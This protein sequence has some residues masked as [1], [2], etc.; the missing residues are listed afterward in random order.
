VRADARAGPDRW[1]ASQ[2]VWR[3]AAARR[4]VGAMRT[5]TVVVSL[6]FACA[7]GTPRYASAQ[8]S[9]SLQSQTYHTAW[10]LREGAPAD[11][12]ALAQTRDGYLWLG[13]STGLF[14]F[15]G[16]EFERFV[17]KRSEAL[18][19]PSIASLLAL[20]DGSLYIGY[21][22]GGVSVLTSGHLRTFGV[23]DG[24]RGGSV[25]ALV[26]DSNGV[27]L[28][29]SNDG[30]FEQHGAHWMHISSDDGLPAGSIRYAMV[31][32]VG[33][34][35]VAIL[36]VGIFSRERHAA[37]FVRRA[38]GSGTD[39][40]KPLAAEWSIAETA[41]GDLLGVRLTGG[42]QVIFDLA[43]SPSRNLTPDAADLTGFVFAD[44]D[45]LVWIS[46]AGGTQRYIAQRRSRGGV[47]LKPLD[48][49]TR[50]TGMSGD[51]MV[52]MITDRE[53]NVWTGTE[54]GLDR[55]R[56]PKLTRVGLPTRFVSPAIA[57]AER[58]DVWAGN[59]FGP[60]VHVSDGVTQ[61]SLEPRYVQATFR[62]PTG[63]IWLGTEEGSVWH[64]SGQSFVR[65]AVPASVNNAPIQGLAIDVQGNLW[66]SVVRKGVFRRLNG[67]WAANGGM[68]ALPK[69]PAIFISRDSSGALWFGYT[70][71]RL[72]RLANGIVT[73]YGP[74]DGIS[75][76]NVTALHVAHGHVWIGGESGLQRF[77]GQQFMSVVGTDDSPF[78]GLTG[79]V[80]RAS[81]E[82]WLNGADGVTRVD[83][84][85]I[86]NVLRHTTNRVD[87]ERFDARDG[88]DGAAP[89]LRPLP[90]AVAGA[91][92]TL[93]V[94]TSKSAFQL[95]PAHIRRNAIPPPV[96][97]RSV[98]ASGRRYDPADTTFLPA[99]TRALQIRY[100]ALSLSIP[101]RVRFRYRLVGS[102]LDWQD[103]GG[104]RDAFYTNLRPGR[105]QFAVVASNDDG[106]WNT[107]GATLN[108][109][110]PPTFAQTPAF[111]GLCLLASGLFAI[112]AYRMRLRA[113]STALRDRFEV[114]LAERTRIAQDLHD[115][116]LQGFTGITL[117]L[118][119]VR[120]GL[121]PNDAGADASL[122]RILT[123]ADATLRE[124]RRAVWDIRAPELEGTD[125]V[126]A[127]NNAARTC[128]GG[129]GIT[130]RLDVV[131]E[132]RR[133]SGDTELSVLRI[134]REAVLNAVQH[135]AA[136]VITI[137]FGF[138]AHALTLRIADDGV[139]VDEVTADFATQR[140]HWGIAGMR[141]RAARLGGSLTIS[142]ARHRGTVVLLTLPTTVA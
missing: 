83:S 132:R 138:D 97:I 4:I 139:G 51:V 112:A 13:T 43:G 128:I 8:I 105:Y 74:A 107:E 22:F 142:R 39:E 137:E 2:A 25:G 111:L 126:D 63:R 131:G 106:V 101:E 56:H 10:T 65:D 34:L 82:L 49:L 120:R 133:L 70:D 6:L 62:E 30:V 134:G 135:S 44:R 95:D 93:W 122:E 109:V 58:G 19:S 46:T 41:S 24:L 20:P 113:V 33:T 86:G 91:D 136:T 32:R 84:T 96:F 81:G 31:D 89:Q 54:G 40:R 116:L 9:R 88:L 3:G 87:F 80:E 15:D 104:R 55:F 29:A 100:T 78:R 18:R 121:T 102:D 61:T 129:T 72:A 59:I 123:D 26:R 45:T 66:I 64:F 37:R 103:A 42:R 90:T 141:E 79:I 57:P 124:A 115:T 12:F 77:D 117:Q 27:V 14:R 16:V 75:V 114:R 36:N 68:D 28:A 21:M 76:G 130:M 71:D 48:R 23:T 85:A 53:G 7:P 60:T 69:A 73:N 119:G 67:V 1:R 17:P 47:E 99:S 118:Q 35:W 140:G 38:T 52:S 110:I 108:V 5:R 92:G 125:T 98:I 94:T 127:L 50:A 11:V